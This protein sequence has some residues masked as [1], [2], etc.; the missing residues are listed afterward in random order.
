[1]SRSIQTCVLA[2]AVAATSTACGEDTVLEPGADYSDGRLSARPAAPSGALFQAGEH[3]ID[4]GLERDPLLYVP[5]G[6]DPT[7]PTPL[8]VLF[9]G[10]EGSGEAWRVVYEHADRLG[11]ILLIMQSHEGIWDF[12]LESGF[13]RD[14]AAVDGALDVVFDR[15]SIDP[16]RIGF[17]GFSAG[18]TYSVQLGHRNPELVRHIIAWSGEFYPVEAREPLPRVFITHGTR[19]A[20]LPVFGARRLVDVLE[21]KGFDVTYHEFDGGHVVPLDLLRAGF[22][23]L[24]E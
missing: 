10:S 22:D 13:D 12:F 15:A 2:L 23:W 19:D 3:V 21:L 9:H 24:V 5:A 16:T 7:E 6:H 1:M 14:A 18:A 4:L 17:G 11:V 20:E 8:L